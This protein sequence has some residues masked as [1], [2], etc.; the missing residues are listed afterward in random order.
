MENQLPQ[1]WQNKLNILDI[2]F[3]P[4]LNIHT[5]KIFAVEA[6]L[7]NYKEVGF[8]SIFSL[9]DEAYQKNILYS[10]D[11]ALRRKTIKKFTSIDIYDNIKL[12]YN[13]DNR[14]FEM[15][16][17]AQGNTKKILSDYN[18]KKDTI[19]FEISE[20]HQLDGVH[21]MQT[22]MKHYKDNNYCI[23]IDDFGVGYSGYKLLHDVKPDILKID[24]FFL[25]DV[26]KHQK[27]KVMLKSITH[28]AVQLGI[29]VVA[30]GI[31]TKEE[32]LICRDVGCHLIQGYLIQRP[33]LDVNKIQSTYSDILKLVNKDAR[34]SEKKYAISGYINKVPTL[35][36]KTKM[37][38]VIEYFKQN[39]EETIIPIVNS[40]NQPV[41]ILQ[42]TQIKDF[43]YSPYGR[44]LLL[45]D[46]SSKSKLKNLLHPCAI[47]DINS[48]MSTIIELFSNNFESIGIIIT[49]DSEYYGFLSPR[50]I[51]TIM[52]EENLLFAREQNPLTKLPGN[53]MIE[54]YITDASKSNEKYLLCY[55]DL[56]NF[57]AFNDVYGFRNGD[58][59]IQLFA[60]ILRKNLPVEFFKAHIGGDDFFAGVKS[61]E[62]EEFSFITDV[63]NVVSKFTNDVI[64]FYSQ[65]DKQR[66]Y[67]LS[68]DRDGNKKQFPLLSVSASILIVHEKT[69]NRSIENINNI[70]SI[71]KKVAKDEST[72]VS[73]S[74]MI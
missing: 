4:I 67:I 1:E 44:S 50:A 64:E 24:R 62:K 35:Y 73:L 25:Q 39:Q 60:D 23:A 32:L 57:K 48:D 13:L 31:E 66:G 9:F 7:R 6:L 54:K 47:A 59:V 61:N 63:D 33:T 30:E 5:G 14:L 46:G 2:A 70:L 29:Q 34:L 41:G 36:I 65:D 10:F 21:D 8:E 53:T 45:N 72:H 17:F 22:I 19:C 49:K 12:F 56:D 42:D 69:D 26:H 38:A 3:Q 37:S 51:I 15:P 68:K 43:L 58:R 11:I 71:Q 18:I 40:Y 27:K 28:L 52:N 74:C 55:F 16:N 20:R